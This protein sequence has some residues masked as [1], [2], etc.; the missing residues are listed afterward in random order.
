MSCAEE[1]FVMGSNQENCGSSQTSPKSRR[2]GAGS[3]PVNRE[4]L[5]NANAATPPPIPVTKQ[6]SR[7]VTINDR[8]ARTR[9]SDTGAVMVETLSQAGV[10]NPPVHLHLFIPQFF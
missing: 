5:F 6:N 7:L 9:L 1:W 3:S 10:F 2:S 4:P 8:F